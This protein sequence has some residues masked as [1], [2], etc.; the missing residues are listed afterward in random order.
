MKEVVA[1][2]GV[3]TV[4]IVLDDASHNPEFEVVSFEELMPLLAPFSVYA[5]EDITDSNDLLMQRMN[6]IVATQMQVDGPPDS[7]FQIAMF[8]GIAAAI[9]RPPRHQPRKNSKQGN[10]TIVQLA[11][12]W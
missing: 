12:W 10:L 7:F 3:G 2:I 9:F 5:I 11:D 1:K 6:K 8:K 4:Q